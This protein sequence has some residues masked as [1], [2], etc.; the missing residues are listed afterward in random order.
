MQSFKSLNQD[1]VDELI[2]RV[3]FERE[4][5]DRLACLAKVGASAELQFLQERNTVQQT[6]GRLR[7]NQLDGLR[8]QAILNQ[9][10]KRLRSEL[11]DLQSQL[12]ETIVT[13]R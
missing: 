10:I 3:V 5:M 9:D 2:Q 1:S 12:T 7:E 6:E 13:L 4:I 11:A 8:Q